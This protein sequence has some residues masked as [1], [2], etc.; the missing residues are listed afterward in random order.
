MK[1]VDKRLLKIMESLIP[2]SHAVVAALEA[3]GR[4]RSSKSVNNLIDGIESLIR[5]RMYTTAAQHLKDNGKKVA[6][7]A[8][9]QLLRTPKTTV[10]RLKHITPKEVVSRAKKM[11][12]SRTPKRKRKGGK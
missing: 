12:K 3:L 8:I 10:E 6:N 1:H 11:P 5:M 2:S 7:R 4:E 9:A